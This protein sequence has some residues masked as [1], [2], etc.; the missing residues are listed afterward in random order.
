MNNLTSYAF[1]LLSIFSSFIFLIFIQIFYP[2]KAFELFVNNLAISLVICVLIR[3]GLELIILRKDF[4]Y[5][6]NQKEK[7]LLILIISINLIF[8]IL[9]EFHIFGHKIDL[10]I[11]ILCFFININFI[12]A[13]FYRKDGEDIDLM[14]KTQIS[15]VF[16]AFLSSVLCIKYDLNLD[17]III[18]TVGYVPSLFFI[19]FKFHKSKNNKSSSEKSPD[20]IFNNYI[21]SL[22]NVFWQNLDVIFLSILIS[23]ETSAIYFMT[24]KIANFSGMPLLIEN[25]KNGKQ[26]RQTNSYF[27]YFDRN[28]RKNLVF[29]TIILSIL[30]SFL[31][32]INPIDIRIDIFGMIIIIV[33]HCLC[34]LFGPVGQYYH[35]HG[36]LKSSNI[37]LL[38]GIICNLLTTYLLV[39][40][41]IH[42]A[43]YISISLS[44]ILWRYYLYNLEKNKNENCNNWA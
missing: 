3:G 27:Y 16:I 28:K 41:D 17:I 15:P 35:I 25:L 34:S 29:E 7:T 14:V 1:R 43:P 10:K 42:L 39:L 38:I 21:H 2:N 32:F 9:P 20:H 24:L 11:S 8:L 33:S 36:K 31:V 12:L 18:Y 19:L 40:A 44:Y 26:L 5:F 13:S 37:S 6:N 4:E 23:K 30:I 22:L